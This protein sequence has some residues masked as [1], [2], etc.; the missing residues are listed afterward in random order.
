MNTTEV[1]K[2]L[3]SLMDASSGTEDDIQLAKIVEEM[4]M[5]AIEI[6]PSYSGLPVFNRP[7]G[8]LYYIVNEDVFIWYNGSV[9]ASKSAAIPNVEVWTWGLSTGAVTLEDAIPR[10]SPVS[11][12]TLMGF[13]VLDW[14]DI[15]T[16]KNNAFFLSSY[17]SI[18]GIGVNDPPFEVLGEGHPEFSTFTDNRTSF[19]V[20]VLT[21]YND[22]KKVGV[23]WNTVF[24][25]RENGTLWSW[26]QN[27]TGLG[28][29][30][31]SEIPNTAENPNL[32][33]GGFTDWSDVRCGYFNAHGLR[34]NGTIWS[35]GRNDNGVHGSGLTGTES[36]TS[37]PVSVV[38]GF[39]DW[40]FFDPSA[41]GSSVLAIRSDNSVWAWGWNSNG[42]LGD[43]TVIARSSPVSVVGGISAT[44]VA[45]G[46][47]HGM[48][49]SDSGSIWS[50][51]LGNNGKIGDNSIVSRSSP[52]SVVGGF[53]DWSD[54]AAGMDVSFGLRQ[55][56]TLWAWG[57]N[58]G[59]FHAGQL[60]DNTVISKSSPVSVVGG[61]TDWLS[62]PTRPMLVSSSFT[63]PLFFRKKNIE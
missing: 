24:G 29:N 41:T 48:I 27:Y 15:N 18:W 40:T 30:G 57:I 44:K 59:T 63:R 50:W 26:G 52:V 11:I 55:N 19:P 23:A 28:G 14:A 45:M 60:G 12:P 7:V 3:K 16:G 35:W 49:L 5:G 25:I 51:G 47:S 32:V 13:N 61:I 39:T 43:G 56:G 21:P 36:R 4:D 53:T 8:K 37:S 9:W 17:G 42:R 46:T 1:Y 34:E 31:I 10:S 54:I 6:L 2:R 58:A 38:G 20:Q 22:W 33:A 62:F